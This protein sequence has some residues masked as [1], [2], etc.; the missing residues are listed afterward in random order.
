MFSFI[1][2]KNKFCQIIIKFFLPVYAY[3]VYHPE[4]YLNYMGTND[5]T[6]AVSVHAHAYV[7]DVNDN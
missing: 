4:K 2:A 6:L 7:D 1:N 5:T 3:F